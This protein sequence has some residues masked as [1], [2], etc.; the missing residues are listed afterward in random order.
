[1]AFMNDILSQV[2][3]EITTQKER[4]Y[5]WTHSVR[6]YETLLRIQQIAG[7][8]RL[9][10]LDIGCFPYHVG[11]ALELLGHTM[12]GIASYHEKIKNDKIAIVNIE[13]E[14]FPYKDN[15]FDVVLFNEV[16]EHLPQS[17]I[18]ALKE[19]HRVTK[20]GGYMM[21][22]TPNIARSI[23]RGKLLFGKNVMYP[24]TVYFEENG[25]GNTIYHRHNREYTLDELTQIVKETDWNIETSEYFI[26]YTPFRKRAVP[27]S[28]LFFIGKL[29]NY[30]LMLLFPAL[31][32]TLFVVGK[33]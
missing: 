13:T 18:P 32:D 28:V 1:M 10:I 27:D 19:I 5:F 20:K 26:S 14:K 16:I 24:I 11:R 12:Y 33:K 31:Q 3:Q 7:Q 2:E 15:F 21:I 29:A 22:T 4:E 30:Y 9:T 17:P 8:N 6:Y 25:K 23:N